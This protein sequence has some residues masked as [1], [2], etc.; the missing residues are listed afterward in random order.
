MFSYRSLPTAQMP[1]KPPSGEQVNCAVERRFN[2]SV[3]LA[4]DERG[5]A[6][7]ERHFLKQNGSCL[8]KHKI[9]RQKTVRYSF[10]A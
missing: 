7:S 4:T 8:P 9:G 5:V 3:A 2:G 1:R 10:A 6:G